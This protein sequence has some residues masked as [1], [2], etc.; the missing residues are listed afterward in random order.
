MTNVNQVRAQTPTPTPTTT[1]T[2]DT[3]SNSDL[4]NAVKNK[5]DSLRK[6]AGSKG[7]ESIKEQLNE[8]QGLE[9]LKQQ[10]S[11]IQKL[12]SITKGD[13]VS[14]KNQ[15]QPGVNPKEEKQYSLFKVDFF[16]KQEKEMK[17]MQK[18][19]ADKAKAHP[20]NK[21]HKKNLLEITR[22]LKE[23]NDAK[24]FWSK[25]ANFWTKLAG[26]KPSGKNQPQIDKLSFQLVKLQNQ[27][28]QI[29]PGDGSKIH[30][31]EAKGINTQL[32]SIKAQI[33]KLHTEI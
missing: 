19:Y 27:M 2:E 32:A 16:T 26:A 17:A 12:E 18:V 24:K 28:D 5:I 23:V 21:E 20:E 11:L 30:K 13:A 14:P 25:E 7:L 22:E 9:S 6:A 31:S 8:I 3:T 29:L 33:A 1:R 10:L 4:L 15:A